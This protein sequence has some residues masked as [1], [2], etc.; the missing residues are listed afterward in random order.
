MATKNT[1]PKTGIVAAAVLCCLVLPSLRGQDQEPPAP[2][3]PLAATPAQSP[4]PLEDLYRD[5]FW[6]V[7]WRPPE[8]DSPSEGESPAEEETPIKWD[9]ALDKLRVIGISETLDGTYLAVIKGIGL[10][11]AGETVAIEH[12]GLV[13]RWRI[14][15]ISKRGIAPE[16]LDVTPTDE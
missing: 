7:G 5:P 9:E 16:Q 15:R 1:G 4:Q 11:E 12:D 6:P 2:P 3:Q 14:R 10:V 13:Y 8:A